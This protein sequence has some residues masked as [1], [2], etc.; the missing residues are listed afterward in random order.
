MEL[1]LYKGLLVVLLL[2]LCQGQDP[3]LPSPSPESALPSL[4]DVIDA[5][6]AA[7]M[8]AVKISK[9][10]AARAVFE[11]VVEELGPQENVA[12]KPPAT[13]DDTEDELP[14]VVHEHADKEKTTSLS[15][16]N[17]KQ[18]QADPKLNLSEQTLVLPDE[19]EVRQG[20]GLGQELGEKPVES[21]YQLN[22]SAEESVQEVED[23]IPNIARDLVESTQEPKESFELE[24]EGK[25]PSDQKDAELDESQIWSFE[26]ASEGERVEQAG[27]EE[28]K[29]ELAESE[30]VKVQEETDNTDV[31]GEMEEEDGWKKDV[32]AHIESKIQKGGLFELAKQTEPQP[33]QDQEHG[34]VTDDDLKV[35]IVVE[36]KQNKDD[37][38]LVDV[39]G[40]VV[41]VKTEKE[42]VEEE[43][44][45]H[46]DNE[47][48]GGE[49]EVESLIPGSEATDET[50][51]ELESTTPKQEAWKIG[52]IAIAFFLILQTL[53]TVTY[54]LKCKRKRNSCAVPERVCEDGIGAVEH[55]AANAD[56]DEQTTV[57]DLP[58][59]SEIQQETFIM[60]PIHT[61]SMVEKSFSQ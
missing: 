61:H 40:H 13:A 30:L 10:D 53:V 21:I 32:E 16:E 60:T 2:H 56:T 39:G 1:C 14:A 37:Q 9:D 4:V 46:T 49:A 38:R 8:E 57:D 36:E 55:D 11:Q 6:K 45:A 42:D 15:E 23:P 50:S 43:A 47:A 18:E 12:E 27:V 59:R 19:E 24:S 28:G 29:Q 48:V 44:A 20:A 34:L 54:I 35:K 7:F 5:V 31:I 58:E 41:E 26:S 25:N 3:A 33:D 17:A 51:Q 52:V 22:K